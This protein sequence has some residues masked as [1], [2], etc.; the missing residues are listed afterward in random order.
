MKLKDVKEYKEI[1]KNIK[2]EEILDRSIMVK[3]LGITSLEGCPKILYGNLN[4]EKNKLEILKY[5]PK[6]VVGN[7]DC[8]NNKIKTL[9]CSPEEIKG[10]FD[11]SN[12]KL[13]TLEGNLK[14]IYGSFDCRNNS[15][16]KNIKEQII[17]YQIKARKYYTDEGNFSFEDIE[18]EFL[19]YAKNEEIKKI[20]KEKITKIDF[21]L[22]I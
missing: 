11:C 7:F 21:G 18:K 1:L 4:V 17:K 6:K 20:N 14:E 5:S 12:N 9:E 19:E 13:L 10:I 3:E 15:K 22:G 16:L 2:P 8:S